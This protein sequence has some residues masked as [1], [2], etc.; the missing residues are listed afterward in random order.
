[1]VMPIPAFLLIHTVQYTPPSDG[2]WGSG[3]NNPIAI[4][5]VR[6]EPKSDVVQ[7][8][9]GVAVVSNTTLFWDA[10]NSTPVDFKE[11]GT[12]TFQTDTYTIDKINEFF[13]EEKL[14]H[15]ELV[16]V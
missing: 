4:E 9:V 7:S 14:H 3:N 6:V 8:G 10:V 1:M 16:L 13:D 12:I 11:Q 15:L 2:S 5:N